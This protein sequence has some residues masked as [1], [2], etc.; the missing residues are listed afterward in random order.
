MDAEGRLQGHNTDGLGLV[1]DIVS[2][3]AGMLAGKRVL[4]LGAGGATRGILLPL[5]REHPAAVMI[6]NRTVARAVA[7]ADA[8]EPAK[9][10]LPTSSLIVPPIIE[11]GGFEDLEG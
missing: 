1:R 9:T 7:V 10:P 8:F 4:I 3:Y 6:A 11:A 5:L 2:N